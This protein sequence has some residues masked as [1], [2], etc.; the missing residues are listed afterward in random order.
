VPL[1]HYQL[2]EYEPYLVLGNIVLLIAG[3]TCASSTN[4]ASSLMLGTRQVCPLSPSAAQVPAAPDQG[5]DLDRQVPARDDVS[6]GADPGEQLD[7]PPR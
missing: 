1:A 7:R 4:V 6:G 2:V 5:R 3:P